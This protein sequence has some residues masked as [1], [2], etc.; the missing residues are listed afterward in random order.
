MS[1]L[2]NAPEPLK[3]EHLLNEFNSGV[4][5]L[6][7]WLKEKA[8]KNE[9]TRGS[10]TFVV[11][12]D[13]M[14]IGFYALASGS[15]N[16]E[17]VSS[18]YKKDM[19]KPIPA[20]VLGRL[21]VDMKYQKMGLGSALLQDALKRVAHAADLVGIKLVMVHVLNKRAEQFYKD[22]GFY[23]ALIENTLMVTVDEILKA[24]D[25]KPFF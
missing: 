17:F 24:M 4:E 5:G 21:A 12:K 20:A 25:K 3:K 6:D 14:V 19:P 11:Q 9:L 13:R 23:P 2:F 16:H 18:K 22:H 1:L 10:R 8:L 15:I 7:H